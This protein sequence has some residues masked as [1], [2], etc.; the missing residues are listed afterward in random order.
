M[1]IDDVDFIDLYRWL[2]NRHKDMKMSFASFDMSVETYFIDK[3][4]LDFEA[5]MN[6]QAA[7]A[8][9]ELELIIPIVSAKQSGYKLVYNKILEEYTKQ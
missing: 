4:D 8:L 6:T 2:W 3:Y 7:H 5:D 1:L 9:L